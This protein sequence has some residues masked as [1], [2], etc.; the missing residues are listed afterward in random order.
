[1][2]KTI[3][4]LLMLLATLQAGEYKAIF[5]CSS[6]DAN[7]IKTRMW[8]IDKTI[9]MIQEK[10]EKTN[11]VLTLNG[12][13]VPMVSKFFLD[14]IPDEDIADIKKAQDYL[15]TL[16]TK[17]DVKDIACAMS[18]KRNLIKQ[19]DVLDFVKIS[20]NSY[21]DTIKYQND[22]YAIMTFK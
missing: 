11:F 9:S 14:I 22:G 5:D 12:G 1:M 10:G 21:I 6:S 13:C 16:A 15:H 4:T 7:Y 17:K 18:L 2:K 20:P 8:L 19:K 3:L